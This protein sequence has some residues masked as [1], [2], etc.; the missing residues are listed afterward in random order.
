MAQAWQYYVLLT[1]NYFDYIHIGKITNKILSSASKLQALDFE[2]TP[3]FV[4][5]THSA[6]F[7]LYML[8]WLLP[9]WGYRTATG[10]LGEQIKIRQRLT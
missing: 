6:Y 4:A 3:P 9:F 2:L 8:S 5:D 10:T 1:F 7:G